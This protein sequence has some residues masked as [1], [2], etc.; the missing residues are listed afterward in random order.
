[1]LMCSPQFSSLGSQNLSDSPKPVNTNG[2]H[3]F[4]T[5]FFA[6][7]S[8]FRITRIWGFPFLFMFLI[9]FIVTSDS[10]IIRRSLSVCLFFFHVTTI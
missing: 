9:I 6:Q 4:V 10:T 7:Y 3:P 2:F 8:Y 1:M 5:E